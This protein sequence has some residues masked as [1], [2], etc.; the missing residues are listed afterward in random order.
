VVD[1]VEKSAHLQQWCHVLIRRYGVV[2]RDLLTRESVA[3]TWSELVPVFRRLELRGEIRGGR[4]ISQVAGEQYGMEST[5]SQLREARELRKADA[6]AD[7]WCVI[8]AVDPLNLIGIL[9]KQARI[10]ANSKTSFVLYQG[11]CVAVKQAGQVEFLESLSG[12]LQYAMRRA[13]QIGYRERETPVFEK[14]LRK[15]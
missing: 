3:P 2:F 10:T 5:I 12:A 11:R 4:F 14:P 13:L 15:P 8:S 6:R 1:P 9:N 7:D